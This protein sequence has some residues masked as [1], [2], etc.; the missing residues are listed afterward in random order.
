MMVKSLLYSQQKLDCRMKKFGGLQ[1]TKT[2]LF[3]LGRVGGVSHF[4]GK[5]FTP[6][7]LPETKVENPAGYAFR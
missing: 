3:G 4:D 1:L 2:D 7:L 5:K 6:F